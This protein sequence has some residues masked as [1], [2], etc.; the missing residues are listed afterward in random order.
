MTRV[1]PVTP[2][3]I[4][5]TLAALTGTPKEIARLARGHD[6]GRLHRAPGPDAW[7]ARDIVAHL[8]ACAD[9][10]GGS[11]RRMLDE[12]HPTIRYVSPRGWIRKT[13]Y[14]AQSFRDSLREFTAARSGLIDSLRTLDGR[15]WSRGATFTGTTAG[16]NATVH[17]YAKRMADHEIVHLDQIRRTLGA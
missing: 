14:L 9:L 1:T 10:W 13:D 15:G 8:R 17:G 7:S 2:A 6:D 3:E 4:Q 5:Q 16:R 12:D 11:I